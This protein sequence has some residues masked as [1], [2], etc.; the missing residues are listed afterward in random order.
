[1][2]LVARTTAENTIMTGVEGRNAACPDAAQELWLVDYDNERLLSSWYES[3]ALSAWYGARP[4]LGDGSRCEVQ[5]G[6]SLV[7]AIAELGIEPTPIA[8]VG[9]SDDAIKVRPLRR[10]RACALTVSGCRGVICVSSLPSFVTII[11]AEDDGDD[12]DGDDDDDDE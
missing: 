4:H 12:D 7:S 3:S 2:L 8:P 9:G 6:G 10:A 11:D 5:E 1:M